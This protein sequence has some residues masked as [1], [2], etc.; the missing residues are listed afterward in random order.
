MPLKRIIFAETKTLSNMTPT[1]KIKA[2]RQMM[3]SQGWDA[4]VISGTDPHSSEYLSARWQ[5]RKFVSGFTGSYGTVVVTRDHAGLWTDTRYFIQAT[6]Q[7]EGTGIELHKLRVPEAV[8]YPEWLAEVMDCNAT[9]ALDGLCMPLATVRHMQNLFAPK[10]IKVVSC[11]D[12]IDALWSDR[13]ALPDAEV[14]ELGVEYSGRSRADKLDWLRATIESKGCGSILLSS[15]DEIAW[16]LNIRSRDIAHTPVVISYLWVSNE[17]AV[18]YAE[19][20]K[21]NDLEIVVYPG[22]DGTFTLYEDEGDNYNYEKGA[23]S[24]ITF[25]WNDR[26]KKLTISE[27]SGEYPGMLKE[28]SFRVR[29]AVSDMHTKVD[30]TGQA[31]TISL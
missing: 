5:A 12:L 28:R 1:E 15:L 17:S 4:I 18:L 10:G 24:T 3:Q 29:L 13:P 25:K 22:A 2:L 11:P 23:Y 16:M 31:K 30:Y 6:A 21:W 27:V 19:E 14:F 20:S 9:V 26:S 7:L 8:D